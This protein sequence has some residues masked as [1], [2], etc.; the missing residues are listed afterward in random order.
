M[1]SP[2]FFGPVN[3]PLYEAAILHCPIICADWEGCREVMGAAA[4]YCDLMQPMTLARHVHRLLTTPAERDALLLAQTALREHILAV[5]Y[6]EILR[7]C[8]QRM[9]Y[10]RKRW[11]VPGADA[12][13]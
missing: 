7:P 4:L 5:N 13:Q 8:L 10:L 12:P 9:A 6:G 3:L 11:Y 2:S 1:V